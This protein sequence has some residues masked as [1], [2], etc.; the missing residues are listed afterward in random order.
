ME[1]RKV[2]SQIMQDL[3]PPQGHR[4]ST[5]ILNEV[6]SREEGQNGTLV[7]QGL[8]AVLNGPHE[9]KGGSRD[10]S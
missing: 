3:C 1:V 10:P 9:G 2:T 5:F 8:S 7:Q 4:N 6:G